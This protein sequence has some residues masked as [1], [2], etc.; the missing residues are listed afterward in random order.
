M[1]ILIL[2]SA[3]CGQH[4]MSV[5]KIGCICIT[6]ALKVVFVVSLSYMYSLPPFLVESYFV[7]FLLTVNIIGGGRGWGDEE[8]GESLLVFPSI[9]RF[10]LIFSLDLFQP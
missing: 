4:R 2:F 7:T 6:G 1:L 10:I 9:E 3:R 5:M 8:G